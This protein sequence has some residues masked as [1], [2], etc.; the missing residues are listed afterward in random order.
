MT[1]LTRPLEKVLAIVNQANE[2]SNDAS[3]AVQLKEFAALPSS[4]KD[5]VQ[6]LFVARVFPLVF[7]DN[8]AVQGSEA[9]EQQR[10]VPW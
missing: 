1:A 3:I 4:E 2:A 9:Y 8:A 7:G 6:P 10:Q 5:K